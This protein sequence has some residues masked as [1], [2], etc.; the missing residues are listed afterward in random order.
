MKFIQKQTDRE[1]KELAVSL[2]GSIYQDECYGTNDLILYEMACREL[3]KRGYSVQE[4]KNLLVKKG[5]KK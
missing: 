4:S 1:L 2:Y 3:G 5:G